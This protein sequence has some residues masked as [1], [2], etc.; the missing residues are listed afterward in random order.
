MEFYVIPPLSRL[1]LMDKG[2]RVFVL[3]QLWKGSENYRD[4]IRAYKEAGK[5]ITL[6]NGAGDHDVTTTQ[7]DLIA[8]VE[9]LMPNEVIPLDVLFDKE[10][11]LYNLTT[12]IG[13]MAQ[14]NLLHK[15]EIFACPQGKDKTEW[16][17]CYREMLSNMYVKTIG[18]S[19]ITVPY[20]YGAGKDDQGIMEGRHL[21]YEQLKK[22]GILTKPIHCLGAGDPREFIKYIGDPMMRS[23]DSCF[24]VWAAMN[25]I[26]WSEGNFERVKTPHN[27]FTMRLSE[28]A[29]R[30]ALS[31]IDFLKKVLEVGEKQ[32]EL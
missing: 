7:E 6:D 25:G 11:T 23:T 16:L 15:V 27:Y 5:W 19:K 13:M 14:R 29:D 22:E 17:E 18:F 4:T 30:I 3:A 10:A 24:S 9:D 21:C 12:F 28:E 32:E 31:N 20:V 26:E 8:I 1:D 2:D